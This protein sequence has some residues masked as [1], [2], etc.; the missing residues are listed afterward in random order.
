MPPLSSTVATW[1]LALRLRERR[2]RLGIE[3]ETITEA[4]GFTRNY[5]SAVENER[6]IL[7]EE[8][9]A[10]LMELFEFDHD[11]QRE[12]LALRESAKQRGWW[13]QFSGLFSD[14]LQRFFGLEHG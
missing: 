5:W 1:E 2:D 14:R 6:R 9:L 7:A 12:L 10:A 13:A 3:V 4:L 8:K 11:E